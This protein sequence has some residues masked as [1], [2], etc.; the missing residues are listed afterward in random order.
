MFKSF[1]KALAAFWAC[2]MLGG[3][4]APAERAVADVADKAANPVI[5]DKKTVSAVPERFDR[6][7]AEQFEQEEDRLRE[8]GRNN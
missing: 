2:A 5:T 6:V 4:D 1:I 3:C 7:R 8:R